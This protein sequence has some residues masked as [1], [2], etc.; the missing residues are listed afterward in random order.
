MSVIKSYGALLSNLMMIIT[1]AVTVALTQTHTESPN[2]LEGTPTTEISLYPIENCTSTRRSR[3]S[4]IN[5]R[6]D[7][8]MSPIAVK[9]LADAHYGTSSV[10]QEK[11]KKMDSMQ[12]RDLVGCLKPGAVIFVDTVSL[13][14]FFKDYY[15][16]IKVN[17]VLV[18]GDTD[19][20]APEALDTEYMIDKF[21]MPNSTVIHW[22]AM[23][24]NRN[25]DPVRFTCLMNGISQ[26]NGQAKYLRNAFYSD[27]G[28]VASPKSSSEVNADIYRFKSPYH[29]NEIDID[30]KISNLHRKL[31]TTVY[32]TTRVE[33]MKGNFMRRLNQTFENSYVTV[34]NKNTSHNLLVSFSVASNMGVRGPAW[35]HFC[36]NTGKRTLSHCIFEAMPLSA[37]YRLVSSSRFVLSPHGAGLDCYRTYEALYLG[38]Y[39]VVRKSSLDKIYENL[40]VLIVDEWADVTDQLLND[41]YHRFLSAEFNFDKLFTKY[42][43]RRFRGFGHETYSYVAGPHG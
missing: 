35:N 37:L 28:I 34:R 3:F 38:A 15:D 40:P 7:K 17:F 42:W 18:S 19:L 13:N 25:P 2:V 20:S 1:V 4:M 9:L 33:K 12:L 16:K 32:N 6:P 29:G 26:W 5:Y 30:A 41:T 27:L 23:N 39:V 14:I 36:N 31:R 43:F 10:P 22:F 24:C 21:L 8:F 11:Q